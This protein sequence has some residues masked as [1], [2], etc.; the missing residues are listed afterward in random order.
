MKHD[1]NKLKSQLIPLYTAL[2]NDCNAKDTLSPFIMQW[3]DKFPVNQN[4][5][6]IFYGRATNGWC[7]TW[8][9]NVLFNDNDENRGWARS[10]QMVW[11]ENQW[12]ES[13]NGYIASKSQ[14]WNIVKGVSV[15]FYGEEWFKFVAWSNICKVAPKLNG[16]PSDS[17]FYKTLGN[18]LNVFRTELDF[19]SPKYIILLTDGIKKDKETII[20]WTS[21]YISCL[22]NDVPSP[23]LY[24]KA[25]DDE[26]P[27]FK[28]RVYK[29]G[30][31]Y[32]ILSMHPQKRKVELHKDAIIEIIEDI[33][34][35]RLL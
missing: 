6:I 14:F 9:F 24:E 1:I 33:E 21:D 2:R 13:E 8:D 28:I 23:I 11:V 31:R 16:N 20:D 17:L 19:W 5:G 12:T 26:Y 18:N 32:I 29:I 25:W 10:N 15:R 30:D 27:N 3:G 22:N 7:G 34:Q 4:D 35:K